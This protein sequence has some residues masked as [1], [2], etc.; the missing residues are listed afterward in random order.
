MR[1]T[2]VEEQIQWI[3]LYVQGGS[4]NVW[5]KNLLENLETGEA[6]FGLVREFLLKLRKKFGGGDEEL[7]KVAKLRR[8]NYRRICVG[9]SKSNKR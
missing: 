3:L 9:I 6:E 1:E 8:K 4:A 2:I 7:V 5:K